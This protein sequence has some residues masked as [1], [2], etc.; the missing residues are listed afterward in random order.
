M[1]VTRRKLLCGAG[2]LAGAVLLGGNVLGSGRRKRSRRKPPS[3]A[4]VSDSGPLSGAKLYADVISYYNLGEHRTAS[5]VDLRTSQWMLEQLRAAG[6]KAT[7]QTFPLRQFSVRPDQAKHWREQRSELFR[8][9]FRA[10][11]DRNQ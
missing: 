11:P 4:R 5:E 7:L 8:Y 10:R 9:G 2:S 3:K 1:K 6:L